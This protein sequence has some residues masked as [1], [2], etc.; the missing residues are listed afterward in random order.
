MV[1]CKSQ[2]LNLPSLFRLLI[3]LYYI[4]LPAL[5]EYRNQPKVIKFICKQLSCGSDKG[6]INRVMIELNLHKG[7]QEIPKEGPIGLKYGVS[8]T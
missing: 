2:K 7:H 8:I 6:A 1:T 4:Y 3:T 5:K